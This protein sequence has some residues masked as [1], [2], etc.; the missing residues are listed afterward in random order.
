[1]PAAFE[2]CF[3]D[4]WELGTTHEINANNKLGLASARALDLGRWVVLL[5]LLRDG[6]SGG[7]WSRRISGG[8]AIA[9]S[10]LRHARRHLAHGVHVWRVAH[11]GS[12]V[13]RGRAA[14]HLRRRRAVLAWGQRAG[15]A[16]GALR[17]LGIVAS[18]VAG[19]ADARALVVHW[20][21]GG[22]W[23]RRRLRLRL[24]GMGAQRVRVLE[25][26][27]LRL[28][29]LGMCLSLSLSLSLGLGRRRR[30]R[31]LAWRRGTG[32]GGGRL[33]AVNAGGGFAFAETKAL[34]AG[35]QRTHMEEG[36][37]SS[38]GTGRGGAVRS[39][40][41]GRKKG[42]LLADGWVGCLMGTKAQVCRGERIGLR[43][44]QVRFRSEAAAV[45]ATF[46]MVWS[47]F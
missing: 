1:M 40:A 22:A 12:C 17:R 4:T 7:R 47:L 36:K 16:H 20:T 33:D 13:D 10:A 29:R 9:R 32:D 18:R 44:E 38:P 26:V 43:S 19:R 2:A 15:A 41:E 35:V 27:L 6:P 5:K 14:G 21:G 37:K 45:L 24:A 23:R 46:L 3:H 39:G 31:Y 8:L 30:L 28:G 34:E 25:L 42:W 11:G